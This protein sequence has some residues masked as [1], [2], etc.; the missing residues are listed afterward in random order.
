MA[1]ADQVYLRDTPA[2]LL[3]A[4]VASTGVLGWMR[5]NLFSSPANIAL[6]I[7]CLAAVVW[8]VPPLLRFFIFDAVWSGADREACLPSEQHPEPGACWAFLRVWSSYFVYGFYPISERWRVDLFFVLLALGIAWLAWLGAPRRDLG[9]IYFFIVLPIL[10]YILLSGVPMIGLPDV[11][12]S[13]WGGILV[14]IVVATVGIV[15]SLP[16]GILLALGHA[17]GATGFDHLHRICPR[18][19]LDYGPVHG[20][21]H[22]AVVCAGPFCAG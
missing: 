14:T 5:A 4:P 12:T 8:I 10:S 21:R 17:G 18:R 7:I 13:L 11:P 22:V 19:A 1:A 9:A 15:A 6:T 2:K 3:P 16:L 20:E